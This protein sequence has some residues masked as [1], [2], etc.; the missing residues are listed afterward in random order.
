MA[1][2]EYEYTKAD[3]TTVV[4]EEIRSM[5][6]RLNDLE[7]I[8]LQDGNSYLATFRMSVNADMSKS[9]DDEMLN[10]DLPPRHYSPEDVQ[11]DLNARKGRKL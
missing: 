2:Y 3:G 10:S 9:W 11:R 5:S 8:D 6:D 7:V 1:I 4:V